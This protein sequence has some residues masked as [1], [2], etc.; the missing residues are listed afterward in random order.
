MWNIFH[1]SC[2]AELTLGCVGLTAVSHSGLMCQL[3]I[4][5]KGFE[6]GCEDCVGKSNHVLLPKTQHPPVYALGEGSGA[7]APPTAP[8]AWNAWVFAFAC[9]SSAAQEAS[10]C[11]SLFVC[12]IFSCFSTIFCTC[13]EHNSVLFIRE[14]KNPVSE[15]Q[16]FLTYQS[17]KPLRNCPKPSCTLVWDG[18]ELNKRAFLII[19]SL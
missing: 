6:T 13:R 9:P 16:H 4:F 12:I 11:L 15:M 1:F 3:A 10:L 7:A 18:F 8:A 19:E 2:L 5:I 17:A 14:K